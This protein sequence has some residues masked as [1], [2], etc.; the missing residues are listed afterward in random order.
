MILEKYLSLF[1]GDFNLFFMENLPYLQGVFP[2]RVSIKVTR[3]IPSFHLF[4]QTGH[5]EGRSTFLRLFCWRARCESKAKLYA[6]V[7]FI[8]LFFYMNVLM[9]NKDI[10]RYT[11]D[12]IRFESGEWKK[13][14]LSLLCCSESSLWLLRESRVWRRF[15][16][17]HALS[18]LELGC[19]C[20]CVLM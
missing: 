18:V 10:S 12:I 17:L 15:E 2:V 14:S 20:V 4:T 3:C 13:D 7:T 19:W 16:V 5:I 11:R 8:G 9:R 1:F 6:R